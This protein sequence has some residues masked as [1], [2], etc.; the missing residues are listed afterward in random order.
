MIIKRKQW[1][2]T[3]ARINVIMRLVVLAFVYLV[4]TPFLN[5]H[6]IIV[7]NQFERLYQGKISIDE[8]DFSAIERRL[9][10]QAY[11]AIQDN[12]ARL[13]S[14]YPS[15]KQRINRLYQP[16]SSDMPASTQDDFENSSQ[17]LSENI[18]FPQ[19]LLDE[20]YQR[21]TTSSYPLYKRQPNSLYLLTI[22]LNDTLEDELVTLVDNGYI[23]NA[24]LWQK[25]DAK[26]QANHMKQVKNLDTESLG[27]QMKNVT[28][29]TKTHT[30]KKLVVGDAQ[31]YFLESD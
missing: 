29:M 4:N 2:S 6:R 25:V 13:L 27:K 28:I 22:N 5:P 9:G 24:Y 19:S 16:T 14:E 8:F 26:W 3:A 11:L 15:S 30:W 31:F 20:L 10:R 23:V 17:Y 18:P 7:T 1:L 12:K 21:H